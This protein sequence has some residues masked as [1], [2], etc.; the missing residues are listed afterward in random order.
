MCEVANSN[1]NT[2]TQMF[3][4]K[5]PPSPH[6]E[7]SCSPRHE[8]ARPHTNPRANLDVHTYIVHTHQHTNIP[9][10]KYTHS[11]ANFHRIEAECEH[12]DSEVANI[13]MFV[14][15]GYNTPTHQH[16][17]STHRLTLTR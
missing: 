10:H 12:V 16:T 9:T 1:I 13:Y 4:P 15:I 6:G 2:Y 8:G 14:C 17:T 11:Q 7:P 5:H 3:T